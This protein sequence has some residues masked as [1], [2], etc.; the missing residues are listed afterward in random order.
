MKNTPTFNPKSLHHYM[1]TKKHMMKL[2]IDEQLK[3]IKKQQPK[4]E[5]KKIVSE[6]E[7]QTFIVPQVKDKLFW[8]YYILMNGS[9]NYLLLD[10]KKFKEEKEQKINLVEKLRSNKEL[11]KKY[12]WKRNSIE[13]DLVYS[14][15]ISIET[16]MCI[17]AISNINVSIVKNR[18]LY[19]LEEEFDGDCQ[20]VEHRPIGFGCYLLDKTEMDIKYNDFCTSFWKVENIKKPLSA[21]SSYKIASLH[22]ICNKLKLPL[23]NIDGKKLKKKDLYE[24][25]KSNI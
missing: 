22:D 11:L 18:C 24:S 1:F 6:N 7:C 20:I 17:C 12:K 15:E 14:D 10:T 21:I 9:I 25:I 2:Y 5:G 13:T 16:F 4:T 19:T 3:H 23:K 8:C